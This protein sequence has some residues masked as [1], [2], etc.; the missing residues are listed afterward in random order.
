MKG[1]KWLIRR[2][3]LFKNRWVVYRPEHSYRVSFQGDTF[4]AARQAYLKLSAADTR[5]CRYRPK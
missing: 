2:S 1:R 4:E 3:A 5:F